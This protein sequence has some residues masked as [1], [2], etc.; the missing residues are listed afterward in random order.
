MKKLFVAFA[1]LFALAACDIETPT[2][3]EFVTV[4]LADEINISNVKLIDGNQGISELAF[5]ARIHVPLVQGAGLGFMENAHIISRLSFDAAGMTFRLPQDPPGEL[6]KDIAIEFPA[7]FEISDTEARVIAF[8]EIAC[9]ISGEGKYYKFLN[10]YLSLW[11]EKNG[12]YVL[13]YIYCDRPATV[14]G[15]GKDWWN[16][17]MVYDLNLKKGWNMV[18]EWNERGQNKSVTH[19]MPEGMRW[20]QSMYI[21]G[22]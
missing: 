5:V 1:V 4:G 6:L 20:E 18:V 7:G 3:P 17:N 8:T 10:M 21:G 2:E 9:D 22:R 15:E 11:P 16:Q 12:S 14:T 13:K 19:L